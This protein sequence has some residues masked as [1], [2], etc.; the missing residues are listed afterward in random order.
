[1][2]DVPSEMQTVADLP[3]SMIA[4]T[5]NNE[6][7]ISEST[8]EPVDTICISFTNVTEAVDSAQLDTTTVVNQLNH[9]DDATQHTE[10]VSDNCERPETT[11]CSPGSDNES[12]PTVISNNEVPS[13]GSENS[14][15]TTPSKELDKFKRYAL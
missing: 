6:Q 10:S 11:D 3:D 9:A 8:S 15:K 7:K 2:V 13:H 4:D 12:Q 1:V 14:A 5:N